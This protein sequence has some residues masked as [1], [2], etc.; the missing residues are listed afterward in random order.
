MSALLL[1]ILALGVPQEGGPRIEGPYHIETGKPKVGRVTLTQT[2]AMP[3]VSVGEWFVVVADPPS[4]DGQSANGSDLWVPDAPGAEVGRTREAGARRQPTLSA[5]WFADNPA[6][7]AEARVVA[8]Y[9]ITLIPRRLVQGA[10]D[11]PVPPLPQAERAASLRAAGLIDHTDQGFRRWLKDQGLV[12]EKD[13]RDLDFAHRT[14]ETITRTHTYKWI[15]NANPRPSVVCKRGWGECGA[16]SYLFVAS[17]RANKIPARA[18]AGRWAKSSAPGRETDTGTFHVKA[19][20]WAEGVGW[21]PVE[22]S[23]AVSARGRNLNRWFGYDPGDHITFHY[24][25][26]VVQDRQTLLQQGALTISN[27]VGYGR[28]KMTDGL[29]VEFAP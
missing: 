22:V 10:P 26:V 20:F 12:R 17:L 21:V 5:H 13:E 18:L 11:A 27:A 24:D 23:N 3:G 2:F 8:S 19:E 6:A 28:L 1:A 15:G 25:S 16:L 4:H 9:E 29:K 14:L 7:Q